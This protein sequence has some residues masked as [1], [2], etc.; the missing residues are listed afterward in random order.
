MSGQTGESRK[1]VDFSLHSDKDNQ[2]C[3]IC[4]SKAVSINSNDDNDDIIIR[5][6]NK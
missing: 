5:R 6:V 2:V 3:P 4:K 1:R